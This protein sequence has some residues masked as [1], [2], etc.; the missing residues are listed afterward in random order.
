[1]DVR[2]VAATHRDLEGMVAQ[3]TFRADLYYRLKVVRIDVPPLRGRPED[4]VAL[5][6]RFLAPPGEAPVAADPRAREL[7]LAYPWPGNVRELANECHRLRVLAGPGGTVRLPLLSSSIL[8]HAG[9]APRSAPPP[10][11]AGAAPDEKPIEGLWRLDEV[12]KEML[13]RALHRARGNKTLAAK[14]LG[15]PKTSLYNMIAK[16]GIEAG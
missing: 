6:D 10:G 4:V 12:E 15:V 3:G 9:V 1:M 11:E 2:V 16:Y 13:R 8:A 14:L 7:L 5:L